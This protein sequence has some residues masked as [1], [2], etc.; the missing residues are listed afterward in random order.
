[1]GG[2]EEEEDEDGEK[3]QRKVELIDDRRW[4]MK[5]LKADVLQSL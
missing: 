1:M 3:S 5:S 2:R 4:N